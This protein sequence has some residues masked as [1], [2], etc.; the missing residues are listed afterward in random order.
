[1]TDGPQPEGREHLGGFT[2]VQAADLEAALAWGHK[3]AAV[4]A[5]LAIEVRPFAS[6]DGS[7]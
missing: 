3:L 4:L 1:M 6:H 7:D 5:P 2:I